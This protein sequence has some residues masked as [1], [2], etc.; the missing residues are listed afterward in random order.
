MAVEATKKV[1]VYNMM[2]LSPASQDREGP[3]VALLGVRTA[4]ISR[5]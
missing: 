5:R 4:K 2:P 3:R 1:T